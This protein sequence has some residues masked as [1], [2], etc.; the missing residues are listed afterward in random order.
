[1]L[2]LDDILTWPGNIAPFQNIVVC[3]I[4]VLVNTEAKLLLKM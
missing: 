1:M 3:E 4:I 2:S